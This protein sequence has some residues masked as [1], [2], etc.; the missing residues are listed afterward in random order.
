[1][2]KFTT[3]NRVQTKMTLRAI[4]IIEKSTIVHTNL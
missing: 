4:I 3:T 2:L 1:M